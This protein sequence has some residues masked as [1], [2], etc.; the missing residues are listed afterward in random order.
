MNP[1][2]LAYTIRPKIKKKRQELET[3]IPEKKK[4][5]KGNFRE[6]R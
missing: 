1:T 2:N 5:T 6:P 3:E 4:K